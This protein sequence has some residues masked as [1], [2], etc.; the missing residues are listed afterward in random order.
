MCAENLMLKIFSI[1]GK[2]IE[3]FQLKSSEIDNNIRQPLGSLNQG[4]YIIC[5][6]NGSKLYS[7]KII[8]P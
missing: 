3:S 4:V 2:L 5:L 7:K 6:E 8:V 1:D